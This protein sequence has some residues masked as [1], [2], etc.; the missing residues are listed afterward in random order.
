MNRDVLTLQDHFRKVVEEGIGV[1]VS[2]VEN[3]RTTGFLQGDGH[4]ALR[5]FECAS[6]DGQGDRIYCAH[7][8]PE[9]LLLSGGGQDER[10]T[11]G[12]KLRARTRVWLGAEC[13]GC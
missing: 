9:I 4:F 10:L 8:S 11:H 12:T 5:G 1:V 13:T 7:G 2:Q 3:A 6:H